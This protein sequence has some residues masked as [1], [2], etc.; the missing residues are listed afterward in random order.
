MG[1]YRQPGAPAPA[2]LRVRS[3]LELVGLS[4]ATLHRQVRSGHF[5][6][7]VKLGGEK[8]RAVGWRVD[9]VKRWLNER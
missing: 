9:D 1:K 3:V 8:S 5:P 7:P 6:A 4:E 2:I